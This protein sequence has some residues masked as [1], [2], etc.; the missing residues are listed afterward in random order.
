MHIHS[1]KHI[2]D[3][4]NSANDLTYLGSRKEALMLSHRADL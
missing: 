4:P 2:E 3:H 1:H